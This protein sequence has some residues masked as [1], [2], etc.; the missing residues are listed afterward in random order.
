MT[1]LVAIGIGIL[2]ARWITIPILRLSQASQAL[3]LGE[4]QN[5]GIKNDL[6]ETKSI[7]EISTLANSFN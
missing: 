7:T 1:L 3:V 2:T 6:L 5:S 4:W